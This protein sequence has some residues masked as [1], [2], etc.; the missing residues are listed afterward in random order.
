MYIL[1][2]VL[3]CFL[4]PFEAFFSFPSSLYHAISSSVHCKAC[5]KS[6]TRLRMW[7]DYIPVCLSR[8]PTSSSLRIT[9]HYFWYASP[10]LRNQLSVFFNNNFEPVS[11]SLLLF[12]LYSWH[13]KSSFYVHSPLSSSTTPVL[14]HSRGSK[15]IP[16]SR[17]LPSRTDFTAFDHIFSTSV[18]LP[19]SFIFVRFRAID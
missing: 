13:F 5:S 10:F 1:H 6:A 4:S 17:I 8:P 19:V 11:L 14:L 16:V 2:L 15:P 9:D 7:Y 12:L 3:K 18:L